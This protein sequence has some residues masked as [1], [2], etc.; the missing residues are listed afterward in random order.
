MRCGL[1]KDELSVNCLLYAGDQVILTPSAC[2]FQEMVNR[3]NDSVKKRGMKVNF[4]KTKVMV[5]QR[6]KSKT[7]CDILIEV[8]VGV[9]RKDRHRNSD[10]SERC[11][12]KEDVVIR[13]ERGMLRRFGIWKG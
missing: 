10:V 7:E 4:R 5:F 1:R 9:S 13:L 6:S 12:L 2:G 8:C 11:G 3:M